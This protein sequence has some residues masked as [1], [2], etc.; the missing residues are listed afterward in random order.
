MSSE[1]T[2]DI[3]LSSIQKILTERRANYGPPGANFKDIADM[4]NILFQHKL[5]EGKFFVPGDVAQA[6][7][8]VKMC[9]L[10]ETPNHVDSMRDGTGYFTCM[11]EVTHK[12]VI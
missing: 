6:M 12:E 3:I 11:E 7:V 4:W 5:G 10:I 8:A 1:H 2:P 9:R